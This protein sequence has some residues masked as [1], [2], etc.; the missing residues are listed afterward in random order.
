MP[1]FVIG[2]EADRALL[3]LA[4]GAALLGRL[5]PVIRRVA[6][7]VGERVL[8]QIE[9][10]AVE[11]GVGAVH[12]EL[13]VLAELG[14]KIADDARQL[15]PGIADRLHARLHH[16]FLQLGG[17]VREPLQ[18]HLEFG[19]LVAPRDL[20]QLVAREHQLGNHGHQLFQRVHVHADRLVGDL[21]LVLV[22]FLE[23]LALGLGLLVLGLRRFGFRL[24]DDRRHFHFGFAERA[25]KL[26]E[27][28]FARAQRALQRLR[29]QRAD[30]VLR[31]LR[32]VFRGGHRHP[33]ELADQIL[34][35]ALGL[36]LGLLESGQHFL[37]PVDGGEDQRDGFAG[38]RHPVAEFAH[39]GFGGMRERFQPRQPEEAAGPFDRVDE[40][41]DVAEDVR[42]VR[43]L[44]E[45]NELHVD[46]VEALVR[47]GQELA[48]QVVHQ[49]KTFV[50]RHDRSA[51][52]FRERGQCVAKRLKDWLRNAV[53]EGK[54]NHIAWSCGAENSAGIAIDWRRRGRRPETTQTG[55]RA[56][57]TIASPSGASVTVMPQ[58]RASSPV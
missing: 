9:H 51:A 54:N 13:D 56:V 43:L 33:L 36:G 4:G 35:V 3:G 30:R 5:E 19:V 26:V 22:V 12:F 53:Q 44:L 29:H 28:D 52:A 57:S 14:R 41:E 49:P 38:D 1:A 45:A 15:L 8:D 47:L 37:Q 42:V 46:R 31:G 7:H 55:H 40:A 24:F 32:L 17:D 21:R 39:Q 18:R 58:V 34:V 16:A 20:E 11:L 6:H 2:G 25:L 50:A 27:R 48:Q 10:L 23:A